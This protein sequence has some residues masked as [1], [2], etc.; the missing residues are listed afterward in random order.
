MGLL[1]LRLHEFLDEVASGDRAPGAGSVAALATALAA[2]LLAKVARASGGDWAEASAIA[3]QAEALRERAARLAEE[4]AR[5]YGAALSAR[6][7]SGA[8]AGERRDFA[9]GQA[10]APAAEP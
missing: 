9:L 2:G 10:F 6:A 1:E 5:E 4:N 7:E 8:E 3:A